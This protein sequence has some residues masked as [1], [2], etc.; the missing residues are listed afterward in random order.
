MAVRLGTLRRQSLAMMGRS[1]FESSLEEETPV[2][3]PHSW[4]EDDMDQLVAIPETRLSIGGLQRLQTGVREEFLSA[5]ESGMVKADPVEIQRALSIISKLSSIRT[6][7]VF[8]AR[9]HRSGSAATGGGKLSTPTHPSGRPSVLSRGSAPSAGGQ[10]TGPSWLWDVA[11]INNVFAWSLMSLVAIMALTYAY[12]EHLD[13]LLPDDEES[14]VYLSETDHLEKEIE[15][16]AYKKSAYVRLGAAGNRFWFSSGW[17]CLCALAL[18]ILYSH[19]IRWKQCVEYWN[20]KRWKATLDKLSRRMRE[21]SMISESARKAREKR[22]LS[23]KTASNATS[24]HASDRTLPEETTTGKDKS[25]TPRCLPPNDTDAGAAETVQPSKEDSTTSTATSGR[26]RQLSDAWI[27][28]RNFAYGVWLVIVRNV[29]VTGKLFWVNYSVLEVGTLVLQILRMISYCGLELFPLPVTEIP[30]AP[31]AV[32][33]LLCYTSQRGFAIFA[34]IVLPLLYALHAFCVAG[35][36]LQTRVSWNPFSHASLLGLRS[37]GILWML[38]SVIPLLVALWS[39]RTLDALLL[40][41]GSYSYKARQKR[42]VADLHLQEVNQAIA[43][44]EAQKESA[45]PTHALTAVM[46]EGEEGGPTEEGISTADA[47]LSLPRPE[48]AGERPML[49][50]LATKPSLRSGITFYEQFQEIG[51]QEAGGGS[52]AV[53]LTSSKRQ[54]RESRPSSTA[55]RQS[56]FAFFRKPTTQLQSSAQSRRQTGDSKSGSRKG[57]KRKSS[58]QSGGRQLFF[59][60]L[61]MLGNLDDWL[62]TDFQFPKVERSPERRSSRRVSHGVKRG[63]QLGLPG[64]QRPSLLARLAVPGWRDMPQPALR[65]QR[66]D[67]SDKRS[68]VESRKPGRWSIFSTAS[69]RDKKDSLKSMPTRLDDLELQEEG[70]TAAVEKRVSPKQRDRVFSESHASVGRRSQLSIVREGDSPICIR[71]EVLL[72]HAL[73][74]HQPPKNV[75]TEEDCSKEEVPKRAPRISVDSDVPEHI[76]AVDIFIDIDPDLP[77]DQ[78]RRRSTK[79]NSLLDVLGE[80]LL[81]PVPETTQIAADASPHAASSSSCD[82]SPTIS[83]R[84]STSKRGSL[85]EGASEEQSDMKPEMKRLQSIL[86]SDSRPR[87]DRKATRVSIALAPSEHR[88]SISTGEDDR[89][90]RRESELLPANSDLSAARQGTKKPEVKV[91][92]VRVWDVLIAKW[93]SALSL[94]LAWAPFGW[95]IMQTVRAGYVCRHLPGFH[96]CTYPTSPP[97][98]PLE[99]DSIL[100]QNEGLKRETEDFIL[101]GFRIPCDCRVMTTKDD[102][103]IEAFNAAISHYSTL[104]VAAFY[105]ELE[106]AGDRLKHNVTEIS[107]EIGKH[108]KYL[109]L[110]IWEYSAVKV[111]PSSLFELPLLSRA[112]FDSNLIVDLPSSVGEARNLRILSVRNNLLGSLPIEITELKDTLKVLN[113]GINPICS[114]GWLTLDGHSSQLKEMIAKVDPCRRGEEE[115][116][117]REVPCDEQACQDLLRHFVELDSNGDGYACHSETLPMTQTLVPF[118]LWLDLLREMQSLDTLDMRTFGLT[119]DPAQGP[120]YLG[121]CATFKHFTIFATSGRLTCSDDCLTSPPP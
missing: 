65:S 81:P 66:S 77:E 47:A 104:E 13:Y 28:A 117:P 51:G 42:R 52:P 30:A 97:F 32:V 91:P 6:G 87:L 89:E 21:G 110:V 12:S 10:D 19:I 82:S 115:L 40:L 4:D 116:L 67:V 48:Q 72:L 34:S 121:N 99:S 22:L 45:K 57:S 86:K 9:T 1:S 3:E 114:S 70:D 95:I 56:I 96:I 105:P 113:T 38:S 39:L 74:A 90:D 46:E 37:T 119:I 112:Y 23:P 60:Q 106:H 68:K 58:L 26:M 111:L 93:V 109:R 108:L 61:G 71:H 50:V 11:T 62:D 101:P 29:G 2:A 75:H 43:D 27:K 85:D 15:R 69:R 41:K 84:S 54:S 107:E 44:A 33:A 53:S 7:S 17:I 63:S 36:F 118:N 94:L 59:D 14:S 120:D 31:A 102:T 20:F 79:R 83:Q 76:D 80:G 55:I 16:N 73:K 49:P 18:A 103:D 88:T 98:R 5:L 8:V 35:S 25:R 78:G 64:G 92:M 24:P 100:G